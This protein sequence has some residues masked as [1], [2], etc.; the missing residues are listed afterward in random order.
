MAGSRIKGITIAIGGNTTGLQKALSEVNKDLRSTQAQLRDVEKLL[1][2]DPGNTELLAQRQRLYA[3][4]IE[5]TKTKLE[6]LKEAEKQAQQQLAEGKISQEQYEGLQ[7][8]IV[9]TEQSLKKLEDAAAQSNDAMED[10]SASSKD[11]A[12][13]LEDL[14]QAAS[15]STKAVDKAGAAIKDTAQ[16]AKEG[17][18]MVSAATGKVTTA[19]LAAMAAVV[20]A[21]ISYNAELETYTASFETMLGSADKATAVLDQL[22][23]LA[24]STP[25]ELSDLAGATQLLLNYGF[26]ADAAVASMTMLGDIAQGNAEKMT[27]IATAYGQMSSAGKVSLED[28]KQMIEAGFNPLQEITETTGES[29]ASLYERISDGTISVD[30]ITAAMVRSTSAGGKYYQSMERQS[31]TLKGQWSTLQDTFGAA[32][33]K[34]MDGLSDWLSSRGMPAAIEAT[35][36]LGDNFADMIPAIAGVTAGMIALRTAAKFGD[37]LEDLRKL[38]TF[39]GSSAGLIGGA[40]AATLAF[41][42]AVYVGYQ[43]ANQGTEAYQE[44]TNSIDKVKDAAADT[45][46]AMDDLDQSLVD[47]VSSLAN[48]VAP[49]QDYIDRLKDLEAQGELTEGQ[50]AEWRSLL[51]RLVEIYPD[52]RDQ[53]DLETGSIKDGVGAL[54][55]YINSWKDKQALQLF[56]NKYTEALKNQGEAYA[57]LSEQRSNAGAAWQNL[58]TVQASEASI[59]SLVNGYLHENYSSLK[60]AQTAALDYARGNY[61]NSDAMDKMIPTITDLISEVDDAQSAYDDAKRSVEDLSAA[62][63]RAK[64]TTDELGKIMNELADGTITYDEAM[65]RVA[66]L[67]HDATTDMGN[68]ASI[69]REKWAQEIPQVVLLVRRGL[70][71]NLIQAMHQA[72]FDFATE[73]NRLVT[74]SD[75]ELQKL[76]EDFAQNGDA[77]VQSLIQ[78]LREGETP[79]WEAGS[80]FGGAAASGTAFGASSNTYYNI[81]SN[82][83][84]GFIN[85][86]NSLKYAAFNAAAAIGEGSANATKKKLRIGSPSKLMREYG[87][88]TVEGYIL[89]MEDRRRALEEASTRMASVSLNGFGA[90]QTTQISNHNSTATFGA[91]NVYASPGQDPQAIARAVMQEIESATNR[92]GAVFG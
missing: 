17:A 84:Q 83:I 15:K 44:L 53:I 8:E 57:E 27:R 79:V 10:L 49:A 91:I 87:E 16:D 67:T 60:D 41:A 69:L 30:E 72:G 88:Y 64:T 37:M 61:E 20:G 75:E 36:W 71:E 70:S 14:D 68:D 28:I 5:Q 42:G 80:E 18:D 24:A 19:V 39:L 4:A 82:A 9:A 35:E 66:E 21:G 92:R 47:S 65:A 63:D 74:M 32:T 48:T 13:A 55:D 45:T 76:N 40:T 51:E 7:R 86:M 90:Q 2:A 25:F 62:H 12:D 29:M 34:L 6:A 11:S 77:A 78:S 54:Q 81:G 23:T 73:S 52:L 1:K 56:E 59:L 31:K 89:G 50:Q 46:Q 43:R 58:Q 33:D 38:T 85:G 3:Q 22:R 26:S